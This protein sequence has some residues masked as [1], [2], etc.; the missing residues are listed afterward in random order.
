MFP[1]GFLLAKGHRATIGMHGTT[2]TE[3]K[4]GIKH[5]KGRPVD[6]EKA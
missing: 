6:A 5:V 2:P 1:L 3:T 4:G